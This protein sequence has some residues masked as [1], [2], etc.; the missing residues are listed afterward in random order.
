VDK[1]P[2]AVVQKEKDKVTADLA[3][4]ENLQQQLTKIQAL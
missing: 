3:V 4:L 1:A 2:E